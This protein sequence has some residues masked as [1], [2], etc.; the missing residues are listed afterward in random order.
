ME[1]IMDTREGSSEGTKVGGTIFDVNR[2][3]HTAADL[4]E[5]AY[6]TRLTVLLRATVDTIV[7]QDEGARAGRPKAIGVEYMDGE[8]RR[9]SAYLKEGDGGE[10][11]LAAGALGSPQLLMLS[12]VG[13]REELEK[14]GVRVML[15][16]P[17]VGLGMADNPMNAVFVPSPSPVE[18]S[19]IQVVGITRFGSYV[20]AASGHLFASPSGGGGAAFKN[21]G[22]FS[23]QTGQ[24]S[25]VPPKQRTSE[26]IALAVEAM[27][28]LEPLAFRGGVIIEKVAG[29]LSTGYLRLNT[30]NPDDNPSVT[31]NYFQHPLDLRRCVDGIKT[32]E[33]VIESP[34][35][36]MFRYR[37]ASFE[38]LLNMTAN[39]PMNLLPKNDND[40]Q[41]LEQFCKDTVMTIWHYHGGCQVARVVDHDYRVIG[42]DALRVIDGSTFHRSPGTNPQ[43]TVM[44]LGRY[45]VN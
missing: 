30:S 7:W 31:F 21:F 25:T 11:I 37:N 12:G 16:Q 20:E 36:A 28:S 15:E 24:L 3:R 1:H 38:D 35:F 23:P 14:V 33:R 18:V 19:L 34:A 8:G 45:A 44:M 22:M 43:A 32:I 42:V 39:F 40:T 4:L 9:K 17:M 2:K 5:R 41:S 26:A 27:N 13:P 10:V 6:P 29:P